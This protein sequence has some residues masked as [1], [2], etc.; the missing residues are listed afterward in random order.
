MKKSLLSCLLAISLLLSFVPVLA[1]EENP[2]FVTVSIECPDAEKM[3]RENYLDYSHLLMRYADDKTPIALSYVYDKHIFATIPAENAKRPLEYF[4]SEETAFSDAPSE[5]E[6]S[7]DSF[8]FY[9]MQILSARDIIKGNENGEAL[10]FNNVTRAEAVAMCMRLLG[11]D[12]MTDSDS[13]FEDVEQ[14]AW[15]APA[16][17][18][19]RK[20]GV[21]SGD[22][23]THFS[24]MR[25]VSREET[26]ALIARCLWV[27]GLQKETNVP[28]DELIEELSL[29]DGEEISDWALSAYNTLKTYGTA[30]Y[31]YGDDYENP[32]ISFL[33]YPKDSATRFFSAYVLLHA[34]DILQ[35]YPSQ[36][37]ISLGFD[38]NMPKIDGST[39]TYPF[40]EAVYRSLFL[41]G[42]SHPDMPAKHSKSHA[43]Y[44]RLINGEVDMIFASVYPASDILELAK[45][46]GVELELIPIAYDAMIFFTNSDNPIKGL[47]KKQISEIYVEN[48][49]SNWKA[50]GGTSAR[51][52]PYCRNND[53]GSHAQMER[54]FLNGN[55]I[56]EKIQKEN[57]SVA[58]S[59]ILTDVMNAQTDSPKGYG[60]GYSIYYYFQNMDEFY[61]T[62]K[63]LKL[64]EI[65][66]VYPDDETIA[67]GEY[68]LSNNTYLVL[69]KDE[70]EDSPA[71]KMAEFMLTADGQACVEEAGF[72]ALNPPHPKNFRIERNSSYEEVTAKDGTPLVSISVDYPQICVKKE[73]N[74]IKN[75]NK[76]FLNTQKDFL[77]D[78]RDMAEDVRQ[79]YEN[80][81]EPDEDYDDE[82]YDD[83]FPY[84]NYLTYT[85]HKNTDDILSLTFETSMYTGG[86][87]PFGSKESFTYNVKDKKELKLSDILGK[88]QQ[89]TDKFVIEK[90]YEEY[91]EEELWD[92]EEEAP[93]VSFYVDDFDLVLYFGQYQIGP[94]ALG[95][96]EVIIP[97]DE[98]TE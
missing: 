18:K 32:D 76:L 34:C 53:S 33:A 69:R 80:E 87:H 39:S 96:P 67:S 66:G 46:K 64:L 90:F 94:Y 52:Y 93:Y 7:E 48:K 41:N 97:L 9:V 27:S 49:Y 43:S 57:T 55:E 51:L 11:V 95:F 12:N 40:T 45:E 8:N 74:F 56:N 2:E 38:K 79:Y 3:F 17:T 42:F 63:Y 24:P 37:A 35:V 31:V 1:E 47:T 44:E 25:N 50:L 61:E 78:I 13:G 72:G 20:L 15:Y 28:R 6:Y 54:Y 16:V 14:D 65:D 26:V 86:A 73:T 19:A 77:Q 82:Y 29:N 91:G 89:E 22:D 62:N 85:I 83:F 5:D 92:L 30:E 23:E 36:T 60:L 68:P 70:P 4:I 75:L 84:E 58:M 21:V 88:T 81:E 10:P 71:R 98:L 59:N